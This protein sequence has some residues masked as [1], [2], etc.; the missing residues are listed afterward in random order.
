MNASHVVDHER[1]RSI[2]L[3]CIV[4]NV[5]VLIRFWCQYMNCSIVGFMINNLCLLYVGDGVKRR[6]SRIIGQQVRLEGNPGGTWGKLK[7]TEVYVTCYVT[8]CWVLTGCYTTS[9]QYSYK[10]L[11]CIGSVWHRVPADLLYSVLFF[12]FFMHQADVT[13]EPRSNIGPVGTR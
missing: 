3:L 10:I 6:P 1:E 2:L 7:D 13:D 8:S 9:T 5:W 4:S 12:C 11:I